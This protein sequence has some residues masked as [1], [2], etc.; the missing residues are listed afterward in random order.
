M[1]FWARQF[2]DKSSK[3]QIHGGPCLLI[4]QL[5]TRDVPNKSVVSTC[6]GKS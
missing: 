6:N 2:S 5:T 3:Y 4:T 1:E